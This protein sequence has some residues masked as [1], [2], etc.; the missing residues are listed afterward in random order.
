MGEFH[1]TV[2]DATIADAPTIT[3]L[4]R[5]YIYD[6]SEQTGWPCSDN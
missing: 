2:N 6:F 3:N 1:I 5:Y 4:S